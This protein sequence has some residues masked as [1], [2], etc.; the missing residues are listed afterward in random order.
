MSSYDIVY[1]YTAEVLLMEINTFKIN[2]LFFLVLVLVLLILEFQF[3]L[4]FLLDTS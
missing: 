4:F 3:L 2:V 1:K